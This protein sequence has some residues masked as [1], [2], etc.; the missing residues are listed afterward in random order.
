MNK[1][2]I[3]VLILITTLVSGLNFPIGKMGLTFASP[4]LLLAIRFLAAGLLMLPFIWQRPHPRKAIEWLKIALIGLF[5]SSLVLGLIY[6]SLQTI[7]SSSSSILS[8][9]NPIWTIL[10]GALF[11]GMH[12]RFNQWIGVI[13]GFMG[14]FITLGFHVDLQIGILYGILSGAV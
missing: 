8:S 1:I 7:S 4:F 5:Q 9:T 12:Y 14:V 6:L 13:V 11:F 10:F 2:Q 3:Y